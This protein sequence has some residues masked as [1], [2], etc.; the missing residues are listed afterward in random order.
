ME[1]YIDKMAEDY[2]RSPITIRKTPMDVDAVKLK[3]RP[4][5]DP[6]S[7]KLNPSY[8]SPIG[9]LLFPAVQLR[10]DITFHLSFPVH[11]LSNLSE[12]HMTYAYQIFD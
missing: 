1:P 3:S 6:A 9:K 5:E 4:K 2:N 10:A 8:Q 11:F 7:D 12:K